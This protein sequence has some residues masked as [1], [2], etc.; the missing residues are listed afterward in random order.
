MDTP[1]PNDY[2]ISTDHV[3]NLLIGFTLTSPVKVGVWR[4]GPEH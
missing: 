4:D 1:Y 2:I 3:E